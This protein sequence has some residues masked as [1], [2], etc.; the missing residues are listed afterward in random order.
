MVGR[1]GVWRKRLQLLE[2]LDV[3]DLSCSPQLEH[4]G[5]LFSLCSA[6]GR[7]P[8]HRLRP[9]LRDLGHARDARTLT[10]WT[11]AHLTEAVHV[12]AEA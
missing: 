11:L 12:D 7:A 5:H 9:L 4:L 6:R 1:E 3:L 8:R 2:V 10:D